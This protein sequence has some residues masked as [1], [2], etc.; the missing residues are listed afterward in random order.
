MSAAPESPICAFHQDDEG[1]W[2]ADLACGHSQH[3]RHRPPMEVREWVLTEEGR[4]GR[5]GASL[6][7][8]YCRMPRLP[9][10][11]SEYKR[12]KIFDATTTPAG[13]RSS[14]TTKAGVWG[15]IVVLE[16]RVLYVIENEDDASFVLRPGTPGAIAPEAPHH[17]EPYDDARFFVRFLR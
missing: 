12:T 9:D 5:I 6:P 11:A 10:A 13:L 17:V 15:E 1:H 3:V 14:H 8:R 4:R 16:G 2:V 7:C